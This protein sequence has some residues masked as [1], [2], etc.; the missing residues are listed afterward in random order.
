[1]PILYI[2]KYFTSR[3]SFLAGSGLRTATCCKLR[4]HSM[5]PSI[6]FP[7]APGKKIGAW[8]CLIAALL[9][10]SPLWAAAWQSRSM[11]C[12][13]GGMCPIHQHSKQSPSHPHH[14][15]AAPV[16]C[17]HHSESGM[18]PCSMSCCQTEDR[19][20]V[21][22]IVFVLPHALV[23]S[24]SP[25]FDAPLNVSSACAVLPAIAPPDRPPRQFPS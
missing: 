24:G 11:S 17:E 5:A 4:L 21:A 25:R 6:S 8:V 3:T 2:T 19:S 18:I 14:S 13:D 15:P 20:F 1:M 22:S 9:L 7:I 23:F 12:C 16:T 10:W